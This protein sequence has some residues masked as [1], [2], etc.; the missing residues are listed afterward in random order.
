MIFF[1]VTSTGI[2]SFVAAELQ[3]KGAVLLYEEY[4]W[5]KTERMFISAIKIM[6]LSSRYIHRYA[7]FLVERLSKSSQREEKI[8][9]IKQA[10]SLY[11]KATELNP[12][13]ANHWYKLGKTRLLLHEEI[14]TITK[15]DDS[16]QKDLLDEAMYSFRK[17]IS[18][19]PWDIAMNNYVGNQL[20]GMWSYLDPHY[21]EYTLQIVSYVVS[22]SP[23]Y[24]KEYIYPRLYYFT[25]DFGL[26]QKVTP[27]TFEGH[28]NLYHFLSVHNYTKFLNEQKAKVESYQREK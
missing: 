10:V 24:A 28:M 5:T 2:I 19:D 26:L 3:Y 20:V 17:A 1:I 25:K 21:K 9:Q 11:Q 8:K 14:E 27:N 13:Y 12:R 18:C 15:G 4:N 6:P 7:D 23:L 16:S 22:A